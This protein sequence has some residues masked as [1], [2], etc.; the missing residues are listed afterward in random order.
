MDN[1]TE[2]SNDKESENSSDDFD[3][4]E[5]MRALGDIPDGKESVV[6]EAADDYEKMLKDSGMTDEEI[7]NLLGDDK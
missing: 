5:F 1:S 4:D 7:A 2:A 6:D 3:E